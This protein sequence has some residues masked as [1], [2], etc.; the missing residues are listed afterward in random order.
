MKKPTVPITVTFRHIAPTEPLR[1]YAEK[2][3]AGIVGLVPGA[4][5]AHVIG[6]GVLDRPHDDDV[7]AGALAEPH[8]LHEGA[9]RRAD[10]DRGAD[11]LAS[12]K[13]SKLF[14]PS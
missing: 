2:K 14:S 8:A 13:G 6:A 3:L 11:A 12:S 1:K 7:T 10:L 5:D 4:T 9:G